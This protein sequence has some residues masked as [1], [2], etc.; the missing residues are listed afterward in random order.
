MLK[1][2]LTGKKISE[3]H[4]DPVVLRASIILLIYHLLAHTY[5]N[6][7]KT[8]IDHH[9]ICSYTLSITLKITLK[10]KNAPLISS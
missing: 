6:A 3:K 10:A 5:R 4:G 8:T 1:P 9:N 7:M 2:K